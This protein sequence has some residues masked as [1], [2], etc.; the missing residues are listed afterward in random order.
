HSSDHLPVRRFDQQSKTQTAMTEAP[1][2]NPRTAPSLFTDFFGR[3][4]F[5]D[6]VFTLPSLARAIP[7][8]NIRETPSGY[9]V[10]LSV[11]G[12]RK[13]DF[14]VKL[15]DEVLTIEARRE[16]EK[17]EERERYTRREFRASSFTR[18]FRL[19]KESRPEGITAAY[20]NGILRLIVP[21]SAEAGQSRSKEI[22]IS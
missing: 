10:E 20:D 8:A 2:K 1:V 15:E 3:D 18:S 17:N 11:P 19:P 9:E 21:R 13:E 7:A 22:A 14:K 4:F 12:Y 6:D 5:D 16:E